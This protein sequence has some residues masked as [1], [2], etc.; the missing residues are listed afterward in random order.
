MTLKGEEEIERYVPIQMK[1]KSTVIRKLNLTGWMTI[2]EDNK[3]KALFLAIRQTFFLVVM[4]NEMY[5]V[6]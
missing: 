5:I 1:F 4:C 6:F 2:K 3:E